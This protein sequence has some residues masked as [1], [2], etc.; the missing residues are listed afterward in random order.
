MSALPAPPEGLIDGR[1]HRFAVRAYFEDT[2]LSG[3]VYH[4]NYLRY[5]ERGRSDFLRVAGVSHS[6][7]LESPD[8]AAFAVTKITVEFRRAAR[9][10][11]ALTVRTT[12]DLVKGPRLFIGQRILRGDELIATAQVE[13]ACIDSSGRARRPPPGLVEALRPL[14][15]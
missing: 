2:D 7:L 1:L 15:S 5:F 13:A 4:A 14:F 10:D 3:V 12:Y 6:A 8:P 11:D 9:I